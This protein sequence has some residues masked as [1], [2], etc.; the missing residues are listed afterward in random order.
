ML[1]AHWASQA[2][3]VHPRERTWGRERA[4]FQ[5]C[6]VQRS[7]A[8]PWPG[9]GHPE[10]LAVGGW[11]PLLTGSTPWL[12]LEAGACVCVRARVCMC[13]CVCA[14][15]CSCVC[16][17]VRALAWACMEGDFWDDWDNDPEYF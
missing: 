8:A 1:G 9:G 14:C 4:L 17:C 3:C 11:G 13:V 6:W 15:V 5:E 16:V 12:G 10:A 2:S 7:L